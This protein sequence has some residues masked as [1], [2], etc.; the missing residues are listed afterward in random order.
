MGPGIQ[1]G[2]SMMIKPAA[3]AEETA[4]NSASTAEIKRIYR[5]MYD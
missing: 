4:E 2:S 1:E 3:R 5:F